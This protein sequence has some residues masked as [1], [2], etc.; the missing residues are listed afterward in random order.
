[1][2]AVASWQDRGPR[3]LVDTHTYELDSA[4]VGDRL[5]VSVAVPPGAGDGPF[6][7]LVVLD[8]FATFDI[9][10]GVSRTLSLLG[11]GAF[12]PLLVVGVG[13]EADPLTILS[14]RFRDLTP[15]DAP[16]PDA[17]AGLPP[18][19]G[20]GGG[21]RFLDAIADEVLP[22]VAARHGADAGD[23][24]LVG[25]SLGGLLGLQA[26]LQRPALFRRLLLASPS[27]WWDDAWV[28][29][30]EAETAADRASL[31][32]DLYLAVGDLEETATTRQW[33]VA[34]P[35]EAVAMAS[36]VSNARTLVDQLRRRAA[37]DVRVHLEVLPDE[38]HSTVFPAALSRGLL[39]LFTRPA[40]GIEPPPA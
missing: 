10:V 5:Q 16:I 33:P 31:T 17:V 11:M 26:L 30:A 21:A 3:V 37:G 22:Q 9:V 27:I 35:P 15:T 34:M 25:W 24:T 8:P 29:R 13:Y 39:R 2:P 7:T 20:L 14:L 19:H 38:H 4:R 6:A 23:A 1:L 12:P 36:M 32:A 28:L 40:P 18:T